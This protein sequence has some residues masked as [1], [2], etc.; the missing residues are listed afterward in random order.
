M[1]IV[2]CEFIA[3]HNLRAITLWMYF[4]PGILLLC[5]MSDFEL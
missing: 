5:M 1:V 3:C 4:I 2:L